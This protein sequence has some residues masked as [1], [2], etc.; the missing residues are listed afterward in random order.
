[1]H[2]FNFS[3]QSHSYM[4]LNIPIWYEYFA[5]LYEAQSAGAAEYTNWISVKG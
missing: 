1:M 3:N 4:I 5:Q 2:F